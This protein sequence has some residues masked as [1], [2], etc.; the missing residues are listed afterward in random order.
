MEKKKYYKLSIATLIISIM[1]LMTFIP[2]IFQIPLLAN[3]R[4]MWAGANMLFVMLGFILSVI[5]VKSKESRS[6]VNIVAMLVSIFW[7]LLII[8]IVGLAVLLSVI[9]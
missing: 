3:V 8:G 2:I 7:V 1:P 4:G 5:C 9:E 6:A